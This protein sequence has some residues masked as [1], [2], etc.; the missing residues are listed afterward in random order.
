MQYHTDSDVR[1]EVLK[2]HRFETRLQ[3]LGMILGISMSTFMVMTM[4]DLVKD[5]TELKQFVM[6]RQK[7]PD[8]MK[9]YVQAE[10]RKHEETDL[11][12]KAQIDEKLKILIDD[13][14]QKLE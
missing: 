6:E 14:N 7:M 5:N 11:N 3:S 9:A 10:V 8:K 2:K 4:M 1:N 12:R 13:R